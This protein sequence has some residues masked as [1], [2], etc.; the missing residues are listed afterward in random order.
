MSSEVQ[1]EVAR[2]L[3]ERNTRM[4]DEQ[5]LLEER[6][7]RLEQ[8]ISHSQGSSNLRSSAGRVTQEPQEIDSGTERRKIGKKERDS[9]ESN[10]E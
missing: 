7:Q 1:R 2:A 3:P 10:K 5:K 6:L 4:E 8:E 9:I